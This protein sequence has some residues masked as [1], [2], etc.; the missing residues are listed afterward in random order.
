MNDGTKVGRKSENE[1]HYRL[2]EM[3]FSKSEVRKMDECSF[4]RFPTKQRRNEIFLNGQEKEGTCVSRKYVSNR[5]ARIFFV[6]KDS[7][8]AFCPYSV[9]VWAAETVTGN[10]GRGIGR[11]QSVHAANDEFAKE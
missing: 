3:D 8:R 10:V 9:L 2:L 6:E 7:V 4:H 1:T 5:I 11:A